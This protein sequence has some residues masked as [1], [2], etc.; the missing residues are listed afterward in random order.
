[1]KRS[2]L[3][4]LMLG[5]AVLCAFAQAITLDEAIQASAKEIGER[6]QKDTRIAVLNFNSS[7]P[8]M[9][10]YVIEELNNA[11][12]NDGRLIA[13]DRQ[14]LDL[15]RQELDFNDSGE[16]SNASAQQIG[17]MV[18]AQMIVSGSL[19]LVGGSYRF[20]VQ[21]LEVESAAMR[22]SYA[23]DIQQD[24]LVNSLLAGTEEIADFS[25]SE[26]VRAGALNLLF[27]AGSFMQKDMLGG[28]VTAA[29]EG[30]GVVAFVWGVAGYSSEKDLYDTR[31]E[32]TVLESYY[33]Y[34]LIAG[35]GLYAGGAIYG[36]IRAATYHRPGS[37]V[38]MNNPPPL[39]IG[40][41]S[42]RR[43]NAGLQVSYTLRY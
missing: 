12:V 36:I 16:V 34:P 2:F 38:V 40:M 24:Q 35:I 28:G 8:R 14:R 21:A 27:G 29:L 20:R 18:G 25:T 43:G 10:T 32:Q 1:M 15:I 22:Y 26:R 6:L 23:K 37:V 5:A 4:A 42:D 13:V 30:L 33:A 17:R 31:R 7:S 19:N 39:N 11:I 3:T 9:A 41:V